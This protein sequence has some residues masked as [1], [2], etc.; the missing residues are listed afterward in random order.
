MGKTLELAKIEVIEE[1]ENKMLVKHREQYKK[2]RESELILTQKQE[3]RN[4]RNIDE[5]DRRAE[6]NRGNKAQEITL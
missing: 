1:Y 4:R 2:L 3:A 6:Q 5:Q